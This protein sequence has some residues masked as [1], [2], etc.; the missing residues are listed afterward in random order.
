MF[1]YIAFTP[2]GD[3]SHTFSGATR[4]GDVD[5]F[6][7]DILDRVIRNTTDRSWMDI[8]EIVYLWATKVVVDVRT[9]ERNLCRKVGDADVP[10]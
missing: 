3:V 8:V 7:V 10:N 6:E 4:I 2:K 1:W 9:F 5:V